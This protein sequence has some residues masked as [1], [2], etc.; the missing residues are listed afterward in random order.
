MSGR[1]VLIVED[2]MMVVLYLEDVL[3]SLGHT[4]AAT[5]GRLD[6]AVELA[7]TADVDFAMLDL[8]LAGAR[9]Y[10]VAEALRQRAIPFAFATGYG[11]GG[12]A[13]EYADVPTLT[14]PFRIE[15]IA[16][17]LDRS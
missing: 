6:Q 15:D 13:A 2:E 11:A 8:N 4:V 10:P 16:S 7:Q 9:T 1:K 3:Q 12:I 14:K 5:A 17:L